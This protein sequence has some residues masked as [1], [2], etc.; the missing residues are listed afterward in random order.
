ME[1]EA[2]EEEVIVLSCPTFFNV[3][4]NTG[5]QTV[6]LGKFVKVV[7]QVNKDHDKMSNG[8]LGIALHEI[9]CI[10]KGADKQLG[11]GQFIPI[12]VLRP[13]LELHRE[14]MLIHVELGSKALASTTD[15]QL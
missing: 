13:H 6:P 4:D 8:V 2:Q 14:S 15:P 5:S 11:L 7:H 9:G 12:I 1:G 3:H 10:G